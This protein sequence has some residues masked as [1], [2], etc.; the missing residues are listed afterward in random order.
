MEHLDS[1]TLP[2]RPAPPPSR[3]SNP[4]A[5]CWTRPGALP[6][7]ESDASAVFAIVD[8]LRQ[9]G[10]RGQIVGPHGVGKSTLLRA[11]VEPLT[12][13]GCHVVLRDVVRSDPGSDITLAEPNTVVLAEGFERLG[14]RARRDWL[15]ESR[16]VGFVVTTHRTYRS[17]HSPLG[18]MARLVPDERR[19][20]TLFDQLIDRRP[21]PV[22]VADALASFS[23]RL[24]NFRDVWFD[25][26]DLHEQ[27]T[28][29]HRTPREMST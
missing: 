25:L 11:L 10:W 13:A 12:K 21:T 23:R 24:G 9:A 18:V 17:W 16:Q 4:F 14:R 22:K 20:V 26:Y 29:Q 2:A 5:T 19:L 6:W 28:R 7:L 1:Q 8:R 3:N 27:R 15:V